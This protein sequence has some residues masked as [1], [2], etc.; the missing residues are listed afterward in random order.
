MESGEAA[1][2]RRPLKSRG[3]AWAAVAAKAALAT[4]ISADGM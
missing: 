4:G 2:N 1:A 3:T